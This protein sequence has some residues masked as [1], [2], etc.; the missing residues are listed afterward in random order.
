MIIFSKNYASSSWCLDELV[1]ILQCQQ[2]NKQTVIPVFYQVDPSHVRRQKES[3]ATAFDKLEERF[4]HEVGKVHK[5]RNALTV[6][7][8][9]S[10][11]DSQVVG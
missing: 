10:G 4:G 3:Y 11:W 5:W 6:A 7:A 2:K 8:N 1:H 9:L